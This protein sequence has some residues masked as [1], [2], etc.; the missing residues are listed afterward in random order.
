M[1]SAIHK[2]TGK[3]WKA[4]NIWKELDDPRNEKWYC[5][6]LHKN[7]VVPVI[8]HKRKEEWVIDHFRTKP[9]FFCSGE[10][11]EHW[12]T[13]INIAKKIKNNSLDLFFRG[14]KISCDFKESDK[15]TEIKIDKNRADI[16][17]E[18]SKYNSFLGSGIVIEVAITE[19]IKSLE[20]KALNWIKNRY[21]ITW[22]FEEPEG[23]IEIKYPYG[24]YQDIVKL[25]DN[26][27]FNWNKYINKKQE[28]MQSGIQEWI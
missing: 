12:N 28:E 18:F 26:L 10:S 3:I 25:C 22:V 4:R 21:S 14:K 11:D 16:L 15:V 6:E 9:G 23:E 1:R 17:F 19:D 7:P 2:T 8:H 20:K 5:C 13:K 24:L 27:I